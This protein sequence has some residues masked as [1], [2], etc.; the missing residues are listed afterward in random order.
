ML[1]AFDLPFSGLWNVQLLAHEAS[2]IAV[3]MEK[4][5]D[6]FGGYVYW[7]LQ[8]V[9]IAWWFIISHLLVV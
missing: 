5:T 4:I 6:K 8:Y 7:R 3:E 1:S 2:L 9:K